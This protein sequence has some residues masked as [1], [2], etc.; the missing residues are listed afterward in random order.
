MTATIP[1]LAQGTWTIDPVHSEV[2]ATV[3]HLGVAKVRANFAEFSGTITVA[4]DGTPSVSADIAV[5]SIDTKNEA[6][7]NHL[8]SADFF[9]VATYPTA[10]FRSTSVRQDGDGYL[11]GGDFTLHGV[12][13]PVELRLEVGGVAQNPQSGA[14]VAGFSATTTIERSDFG[15]NA[16]QGLVGEKVAIALEIEASLA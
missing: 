8:K 13:Q 9:D 1:G 15:V 12:T 16:A 3:R 7:D 11:V 4:E 6:R 14:P 10:T 5:A 2:T